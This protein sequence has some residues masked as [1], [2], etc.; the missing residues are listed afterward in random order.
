MEHSFVKI[1]RQLLDRWAERAFGINAFLPL[2]LL[3]AILGALAA[4]SLPIFQTGSP[5]DLLG[6]RIWKPLQGDFGYLPFI[7]GTFWVTIVAMI[8]AVPACIMTAIF[9]SE[10]ASPATRTILKPILDLLAA[11]PSVVYGVWGVIVIVPLV[12]ESIAPFFKK[13]VGF[14]PLFNSDNPTGYGILT[15]GI[16]LAVMVSPFIIAVVSEVF[17]TV[18]DGQREA[19]LALGAT[20]WQAVRAVVIPQSK[21]GI[22]AGVVLGA[23]RAL[24]ETMAVLM[25]VGNNAL[26]PRSIFDAAYP[27]PALIANNY[28]EM[29]S[30]PLYDSALMGAALILVVIVLF[31]NILSTSVLSRIK[32]VSRA[33]S[34]G[35]S[36]I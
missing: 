27:L 16:V 9:L 7:A 19:V 33:D 30:I 22:I 10:Y 26:M 29:L 25:V 13:T 31:F 24:G 12:Q 5:G 3:T 18:P 15:G 11:I 4:R 32:R 2:L 20:R 36:T 14:L 21:T 34:M 35:S 28:G 23:S 1:N 8:L 6:G 17:N